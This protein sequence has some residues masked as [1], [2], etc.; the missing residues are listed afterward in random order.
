MTV[1]SD[2]A[3]GF[4]WN[5]ERGI[6][7]YPVRDHE[8]AYDAEYF[9]KYV[10]YA[11]T[12]LG[13][14]INGFRLG[15]VQRHAP[16]APLI[17]VGIGSGAFVLARPG[18][19]YGYDINPVGVAWLKERG[20]YRDPYEDPTEALTCWDSLEHLPAPEAIVC[21]AV[22]WLFT[23]LPIYAGPDVVRGSRHYRSDEH[24]WY[25]TSWGLIRMMSDLGF[26]VREVSWTETALGRSEIGSFAFERR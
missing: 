19:T 22:K 8:R 24:F 20:L 12:P 2:E 7:H 1:R 26:E 3:A 16:T 6:G 11:Q 21:D 4:T 17:D 14:A 23:S 13:R 5:H 15:L 18:P 10:A 9:A 25:H